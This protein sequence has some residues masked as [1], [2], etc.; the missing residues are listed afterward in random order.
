[1]AKIAPIAEAEM[2][3]ILENK[4]I[5]DDL[6]GYQTADQGRLMGDDMPAEAV[7]A[8]L[9][10]VSEAHTIAQDFYKLRAKLMGVTQLAYHERNVPYGAL[11]MSYPYP[12]AAALVYE[13]FTDLDPEFGEIFKGFVEKGRVDVFPKKGKSGGAFCATD[14]LSTPTYIL[15]NHTNKLHD[16]LTLAHESGHGLNNEFMRA[17][18]NALS[19]GT[20]LATAEVASTFMED[21]V[22]ERLAKNAT[23]EERLSLYVMKLGDDVSTIFRQ[24]AFYTFEQELHQSFRT[25]GYLSQAAIGSLFKK[26]MEAYMGPAVAQSPG[27]EN[28]WVYVSH[29]RRFFYVYSYASGL[30]ISKAMQRAV[31]KDKAFVEKV[32]VFLSAGLSE[33]PVETFKKMGIDI[34]NPG[35]WQEGLAETKALLLE[36]ESLAKKLG[37]I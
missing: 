18:R 2:N 31:K 36:T 19:F 12:E 1:M 24:A 11:P 30:L 22:L 8:M 20:T 5:S 23:D 34:L 3:A 28:W 37:K 26:H 13:T 4:R 10:A 9:Q 16:V 33:A 6:R 15:L 7:T 27:A 35:F 21:F 17:K 29:F 14:T 25:E 32:K